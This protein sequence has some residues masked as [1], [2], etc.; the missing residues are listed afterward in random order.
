MSEWKQYRDG[1]R[2]RITDEGLIE[3]EGEGIPY[4]NGNP[5]TMTLLFKEYGG[6]IKQACKMFG[7]N[8]PWLAGMVP[9]E[10]ARMDSAPH[11][12]EWDNP[13]MKRYF[14]PLKDSGFGAAKLGY[15]S[16]K[17]LAKIQGF[18]F[19]P[20]S[21]RQEPGDIGPYDTPG[22]ESAG[23]LQCLKSTMLDMIDKHDM[24]IVLEVKGER[25][26]VFPCIGDMMDPERACIFAAAYM[27][28]LRNA[29]RRGVDG[30]EFDFVHLTGAYNAGSVKY[31]DPS[32]GGNR[33][34]LITYSD[35]RTDRAIKW[36]NDCYR[37][38]HLWED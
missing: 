5:T 12:M 17:E 25:L 21:F 38:R 8:V 11:R 35:S 14:K 24:K 32:N 36:H 6:A 16:L 2:W 22:R 10:A 4:S 20:V 37:V 1:H 28:H 18:R 30:H 26:E 33:F 13:K 23:I 29:Y 34:A 15:D 31:D 27:D 9:I 3:V 7:I 19:D